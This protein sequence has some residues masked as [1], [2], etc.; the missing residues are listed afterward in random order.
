MSHP[1]SSSKPLSK[2]ILMLAIVIGLY[3]LANAIDIRRVAFAQAL[4]GLLAATI[5]VVVALGLID[6]RQSPRVGGA[7]KVWALVMIV[8]LLQIPVS[9]YASMT[10][11]IVDAVV[12]MLPVGMAFAIGLW[13]RSKRELASLF[14]LVVVLSFC[15]ALLAW[16][17]ASGGGRYE[18]PTVFAIVGVWILATVPVPDGVIFARHPRAVRIA[19][20]ICLGALLFLILGSRQ[21]TA[22]AVWLLGG[23]MAIIYA[24]LKRPGWKIMIGT[25]LMGVLVVVGTGQIELDERYGQ[26]VE[27][28]R[29][30]LLVSGQYI[31]LGG[32]R[33]QEV[34]DVTQTM[35]REATTLDYVLGFGHGATYI[36]FQSKGGLS[37]N[38]ETGRVHQ[39]H[40]VPFM[41]LLR[42][43]IVGVVAFSWLIL[44]TGRWAIVH[45]RSGRDFVTL[46][47]FIAALMYGMDMLLRNSFVD[48]GFSLVIASVAIYGSLHRSLEADR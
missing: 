2:P 19:A 22:L 48:P 1:Q 26:V 44:S 27:Q 29:L 21:R 39:V 25:T 12:T 11:S 45:F 18:A 28:A 30:D 35:S 43:G 37:L 17:L 14:V 42:Y 34:D 5:A 3:V 16:L 10:Q 33:L 4:F 31:E 47:M 7:M 46:F 9:R 13:V 8:G 24:G 41:V 23:A 38:P 32:E 15:A 40:A 6:R 36:P 20:F